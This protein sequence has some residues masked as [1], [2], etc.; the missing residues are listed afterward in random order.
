MANHT[1]VRRRQLVTAQ[2]GGV[3]I[4]RLSMEMLYTDSNPYAMWMKFFN[5]DWCCARDLLLDALDGTPSGIGDVHIEVRDD[6]V[7]I[8][9][10]SPDGKA[11]LSMSR[12]A[13]EE[14]AARTVEV[15]PRGTESEYV[16]LDAA[17]AAI[18]GADQY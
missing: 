1:E 4:G 2:V 14:F 17:V 12:V 11:R 7:L 13:A 9:F 18:T 16:D 8:S 5:T 10:V 3:D 6:V 15:V